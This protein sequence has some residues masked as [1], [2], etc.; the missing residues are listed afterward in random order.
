VAH[1]ESGLVT[2]LASQQIR[3]VWKLTQ[4]TSASTVWLLPLHSWVKP[5]SGNLLLWCRLPA[6]GPNTVLAAG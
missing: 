1:D 4:A 5:P 6:R 2:P 3:P